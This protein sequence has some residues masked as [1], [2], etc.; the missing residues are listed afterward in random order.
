MK[1]NNYYLYKKILTEFKLFILNSDSI[2]R[3]TIYI[4]IYIQ[5]KALTASAWIWQPHWEKTIWQS[6]LV[7][8]D[9][10]GALWVSGND[11]SAP[12]PCLN[13]ES[14]SDEGFVRSNAVVQTSV[15]VWYLLYIYIYIRREEE[16]WREIFKKMNS[17]FFYVSISIHISSMQ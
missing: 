3:T 4:Y 9:T 7:S 10:T 13:P 15:I 2:F 6:F 8:W 16:M 17:T 12:K 14:S 1:P 5:D 11:T